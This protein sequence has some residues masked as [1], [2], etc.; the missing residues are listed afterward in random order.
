MDF[1]AGQQ[2]QYSK[3]NSQ[4]ARGEEHQAVAMAESITRLKSNETFVEEVKDQ[5]SQRASSVFIDNVFRRI[6]KSHT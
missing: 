5:A 6:D 4:L 2:S 3:K 1:L